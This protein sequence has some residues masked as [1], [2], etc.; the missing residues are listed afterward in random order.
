[1]P[2]TKLDVHGLRNLQL[3]QLHLSPTINLFYGNNGSGK[4]SLLEAAFL[5]GRGRSF[6]S[7]LFHTAIQ[8]DQPQ[9]TVFGLIEQ[10]GVSI[11]L[12][13]TRHRQGG[14]IFKVAGRAVNTASSLA[15][16][17]PLLLINQEGFNLLEGAPIYRRRFVDWGV[18]H[19][20]HAYQQLTQ[21]LQRTLKQR[22]S[23]LRHDRIDDDL[24]ATWDREFV[25]TSEL[26]TEARERYLQSLFPVVDRVLAELS[27]S[28]EGK[29]DLALYA[30][31]DS[32]K[33]LAEVLEAN[34]RRDY[35]FKTTHY[36]PHRADL[37]ISCNR[38]NASDVLSRGQLKILAMAMLIAQGHL[39]HQKTGRH[40][41]YLIDDLAAEL[42][43]KHRYLVAE[44]LRD[45]GA[46][47]VITGVEKRAL[48]NLWGGSY[49]E[50][51]KLFHVEQGQVSEELQESIPDNGGITSSQDSP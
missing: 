12:G 45:L 31:W 33:L 7:R 30:G 42:D 39:Y 23:L 18:F 51:L 36:G 15:E 10:N 46:Q 21:R 48:L 19:V 17:L 14:G 1:M 25:D 13:V 44:L 35:K 47:V 3:V 49:P 24:M 50:N 41:L 28:L 29:V 43:E 16:A 5:L 11:P 27:P 37:R 8:E 26:M 2:L 40:C 22:N 34:R 32:S 38:Y 4:T 9:A 6:R 20:E